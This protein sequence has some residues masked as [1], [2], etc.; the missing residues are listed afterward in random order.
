MDKEQK[1][2]G[3]VH[4]DLSDSS[5]QKWSDMFRNHAKTHSSEKTDPATGEPTSKIKGDETG[6]SP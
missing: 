6:S 3:H 4:A 2:D 5:Q 1:D